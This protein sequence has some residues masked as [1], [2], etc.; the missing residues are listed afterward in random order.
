VVV[1]IVVSLTAFFEPA[2]TASIP[3]VTTPEELILA[4]TLGSVTWSVSLGI[5]SALGGFVTAVAGWRSAFFL[6]ACSFACSAW[7]IGGIALR[8]RLPAARRRIGWWAS[9]G[10]VDLVEGIRYLRGQKPVGSLVL[11]KTGWSLAG[12]LIL[13]HSVFGARV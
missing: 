9:L 8:P 3:N 5:G 2:R 1:A 10:G 6:D 7:L 12:G 4:N 11:V 13:L